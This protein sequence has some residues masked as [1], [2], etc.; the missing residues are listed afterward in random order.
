MSLK[1]KRGAKL[2]TKG[3]K[4]LGMRAPKLRDL[5]RMAGV[6]KQAAAA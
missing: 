5:I 6:H 3:I 2:K 4:L 1:R